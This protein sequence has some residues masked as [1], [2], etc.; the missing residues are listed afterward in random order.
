M[1]YFLWFAEF[2]QKIFLHCSKYTS[3]YFN[4][5][6]IVKYPVSEAVFHCRG[7]KMVVG[8]KSD[9]EMKLNYNL[10]PFA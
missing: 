9:K 3:S 8:T 6:G 4:V 2:L 7:K 1:R 10:Q 5:F